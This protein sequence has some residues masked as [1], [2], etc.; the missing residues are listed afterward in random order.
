MISNQQTN[1]VVDTFLKQQ[2]NMFVYLYGFH[3]E[4]CYIVYREIFKWGDSHM[5]LECFIIKWALIF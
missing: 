4:K 2:K 1:A 5:F 3:L